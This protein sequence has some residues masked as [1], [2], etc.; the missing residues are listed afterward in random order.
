MS[1][2]VA[3]RLSFLLL[4][5]LLWACSTPLWQHAPSEP[6]AILDERSGVTLTVVS[7]PMVFVRLGNSLLGAR[8]Y[9]T[10]VAAEEDTM[11]KYMQLLIV[12][13]WSVSVSGGDVPQPKPNAGKLVVVAD[14]R[15][16]VM[17]PLARIPIDLS[18]SN[19]LFVP[20]TQSIRYVYQTDFKAMRAIASSHELIV[21]LPQEEEQPDTPF[22]L[23]QDGRS[24]LAQLVNQLNGP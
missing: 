11:G 2:R 16:L 1:V 12:Y 19:D 10:L 17:E 9:V 23:W 22:S 6:R 20:K 8:D 24:A 13:R 5:A 4:P 14:G 7:S 15:E 21:K 3:F 18:S